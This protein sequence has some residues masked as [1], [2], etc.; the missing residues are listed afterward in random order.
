MSVAPG[1]HGQGPSPPLVRRFDSAEKLLVGPPMPAQFAAPQYVAADGAQRMW[2]AAAPTQTLTRASSAAALSPR[3][4]GGGGLNGDAELTWLRAALASRDTHIA[5]LER[6]LQAK[7]QERA[8]R[9][10]GL[11]GSVGA[12]PPPALLNSRCW[13]LGSLTGPTEARS[14]STLPLNFATWRSHD[15]GSGC[16][17]PQSLSPRGQEPPPSAAAVAAAQVARA[18]QAA[19]AAQ[20]AAAGG[21]ALSGSG[22]APSL[23]PSWGPPQRRATAPSQ[24]VHAHPTHL[25]TQQQQQQ[26]HAAASAAALPLAEAG[27]RLRSL[28][29]VVVGQALAQ[30]DSGSHT[31]RVPVV[32]RGCFRLGRRSAPGGGAGATAA[33]LGSTA[34]ASCEPGAPAPPPTPTAIVEKPAA[35]WPTLPAG[36]ALPPALGSAAIAAA[37]LATAAAGGAPPCGGI[38]TGGG[39]SSTP[40]TLAPGSLLA[41]FAASPLEVI[42]C[43][44]SGTDTSFGLT[45]KSLPVPSSA[46]EG[47]EPGGLEPEQPLM[48]TPRQERQEEEELE[49]E[50]PPWPERLLPRVLSADRRRRITGESATSTPNSQLRSPRSGTAS[51]RSPRSPRPRSLS[52]RAL[53]GR[54]AAGGGKGTPHRWG[55]RNRGPSSAAAAAPGGSMAATPWD[56]ESPRRRDEAARHASM[57]DRFQKQAEQRSGRSVHQHAGASPNRLQ[58]AAAAVAGDA[59]CGYTPRRGPGAMT[60]PTVPGSHTPRRSLS[61]LAPLL[62]GGASIGGGYQGVLGE[63]VTRVARG[64][65]GYDRGGIWR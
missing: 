48:S 32:E 13:S 39:G 41:C 65:R 1:C 6:R 26:Q 44:A 58:A 54:A 15:G 4:G 23:A 60:A 27:S 52:R 64:A 42:P 55:Q 5:D 14:T 63:P 12:Q 43:S 28:S 53:S 24:L 45:P 36:E 22:S 38:L 21:K 40:P 46:S 37:G 10:Q 19:Q 49:Q 9:V 62:G 3:G 31:P 35:G 50:Q 59:A 57:L 33:A 47:P 2:A 30:G 16:L 61:P 25:L 18:V 8:E 11:S 34:P 17:R 51:G 7:E 56:T 29:P 20:A